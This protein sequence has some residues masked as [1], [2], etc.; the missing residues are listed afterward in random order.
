V[1]GFEK[2]VDVLSAEIDFLTTAYTG[3]GGWIVWAVPAGGEGAPVEGRGARQGNRLFL[4]GPAGVCYRFSEL[5]ARLA[6]RFMRAGMA[7]AIRAKRKRGQAIEN[8][9]LCEIPRFAPPMISMA[10]GRLA[11]PLVSLGERILSL[12]LVFPPRRGPRRKG[13]KSTADSGRT[14]RTLRG[15]ATRK[16]RRKPLES[17]KR[18]RRWR[19]RLQSPT[20]EPIRRT[21]YK[22]RLSGAAAAVALETETAKVAAHP[23][24][25]GDSRRATGRLSGRPF[26]P[27][28]QSEVSM[29]Q[30]QF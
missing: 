23:Q 4:D 28:G 26:A 14:R 2:S 24:I 1:E 30:G 27:T 12:L 7:V 3:F 18:T 20:A 10:Y 9:Q 16:W 15:S 25:G 19:R 6:R 11:K 29:L 22:S 17:L 13:A 5:T 21:P 8:K